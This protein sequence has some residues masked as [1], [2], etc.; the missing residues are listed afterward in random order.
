MLSDRVSRIALSPTFRLN[1]MAR[2]LRESGADVLDFSVGEPDAPT[3][4]AAKQAGKDAI[5]RDLTRYTANEG[6]LALRRAIAAKLQRD[7]GLTYG[8]DEILVSPGAKASLY[9]AMMALFSPGDEVLVPSPYWV[10]YPEQVRLT[11]AEPVFVAA[12]ERN[13]FK[14]TREGLA[15]AIGP[16]T[17]GVVLNYPCN[18]TGAC[19]DRDELTKLAELIVARDLVVLADEI[20]EKLLYD[21][22]A[23]T[24]IAALGAPI[25]ERTVVVNGMSKAFAMT[26]W[27]LGYAA[28]PKAVIDAMARVQS[29][30][31]S[32][33]ASISQ[34]AGLAALTSAE[35]EVRAMV[36][37]FA[38]R[39]EVM[40]AGLR[41]IPG[42]TL[43]APAGAF[44]VFPNVSGVFGRAIGGRTITS[45]QDLAEALLEH[46]RVVVVPGEAFGSPLHV[47]ISFSCETSRIEE[48]LRRI[49]ALLA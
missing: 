31:T 35:D 2:A 30:S 7:N 36:A 49:R 23:F 12:D 43:A 34:E 32:H 17:K 18:P 11:G 29:H 6:T 27:R 33:P 38:R 8:T 9:C 40:V 21:G 42:I 25:R 3:P 26:G 10:S 15:R 41:A 4:R 1:A 37:Q 46:A 44:Y 13:G 14:I 47:R 45:G 28:G 22:R 5:D 24:S 39:R 19:F 20:Y 48:G 16:R